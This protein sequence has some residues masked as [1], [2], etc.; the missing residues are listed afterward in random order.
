LGT[1][2]AAASVIAVAAFVATRAGHQR[3]APETANG[4]ATEALAGRPAATA[5]PNTARNGRSASSP[6]VDANQTPPAPGS[7]QLDA[8]EH[9]RRGERTV[10]ANLG[11]ANNA[12]REALERGIA[13]LQEALRLGYPQRKAA[14]TLIG[15]AYIQIAAGY[16]RNGSDEQKVAYAQAAAVYSEVVALDPSNVRLRLR[17]AELLEP[18]ERRRQLEETVRIAPDDGRAQFGLG[19]ELLEAGDTAGGA[20]H[21]LAAVERFTPAELSSYGRRAVSALRYAG[22]EAEAA[23]A[24]AVIKARTGGSR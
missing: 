12:T 20:R 8:A 1:I 5:G 4:P 13:D 10:E 3:S 14:L 22:L 19:R 21:L 7:P 15:E 2:V 16:V 6:S 17:Y 23:K 18:A 24:E 11:D 9:F